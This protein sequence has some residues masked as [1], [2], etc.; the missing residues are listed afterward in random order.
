MNT[1]SV[2]KRCSACKED[3]PVELFHKNKAKKDGLAHCCTP[4]QK[5]YAKQHYEANKS[6]YFQRN[7]RTRKRA[8]AKLMEQK[9]DTPCTD[10]GQKFHP[11]IM[12]FDHL[13]PSTK[14]S[15]IGRMNAASGRTFTEE[16][17]KCELVCANCHK[18]RT[19]RRNLK[20]PSYSLGILD[21]FA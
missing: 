3:L 19:F 5:V 7:Q 16:L 9:A 20:N 17:A 6:Q 11:Y 21:Q 15:A 4:C 1:E 8:K 2:L 14:I 18:L 10:C 12:E 13:D